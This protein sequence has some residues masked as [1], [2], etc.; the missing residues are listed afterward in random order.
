MSSTVASASESSLHLAA[1]AWCDPRVSDR[2]MDPDLATVFAEILD[3]AKREAEYK[4]ANLGLATT[5]QLLDEL[6]ARAEVNGTINYR[7][8]DP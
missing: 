1:Q 2:E 3:V 5:R 4:H 7:T 8:V 6:R